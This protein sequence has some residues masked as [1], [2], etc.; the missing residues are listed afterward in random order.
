MASFEA[1]YLSPE[2]VNASEWAAFLSEAHEPPIYVQ[3]WF[4]E[5]VT[6]GR[7]S[8]ALVLQSGQIVAGLPLFVKHK[9]LWRYSYQ[10][11]FTQHW[12]PV[13]H[14]R[15]LDV[16]QPYVKLEQVLETLLQALPASLADH[17]FATPPSP[18]F[19]LSFHSAGY[20]LKARYSYQIQP[21]GLT[22]EKTLYKTFA[23]TH[24]RKLKDLPDD[25]QFE[26][27]S[28]QDYLQLL[29]KSGPHFN[30]PIY[31]QTGRHLIEAG[32]KA[33]ALDLTKVA[34][35]GQAVSVLGIFRD[36]RKSHTLIGMMDEVH[37]KLSPMT[38]LYAR[39]ILAAQ[40]NDCIFDFEGSMQ[41]D[42][43]YYFSRFGGTPVPYI[44]LRRR[45][46]TKLT[47]PNRSF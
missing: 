34:H 11:P 35:N 40:Q 27:A 6:N 44:N 10:P 3:P 37:R 39:G 7:W 41:P 46:L 33:E 30:T 21:Q 32:L 36:E 1:A 12:G 18:G 45:C 14:K 43:A 25:Y 20:S 17:Q 42:I 15:L 4:L 28:L 8:L 24:R 16:K 26:T 2:Q 19:M 38:L 13:F 5:A 31:H 47:L 22:E 23:R 9:Y 29:P